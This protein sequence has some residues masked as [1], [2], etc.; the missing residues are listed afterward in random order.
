MGELEKQ[1]L[2]LEEE[3][4]LPSFSNEDAL[5]L[6]LCAVEWI[7]EAGKPMASKEIAAEL[8]KRKFSTGTSPS[9]RLWALG[10]VLRHCGRGQYHKAGQSNHRGLQYPGPG[11]SYDIGQNGRGGPGA[12][13]SGDPGG[14]AGS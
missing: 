14:P 1:L 9:W 12:R 2:K 5:E 10:G 13:L 8:A 3:L 11:R 4:Q 7:R 6:G